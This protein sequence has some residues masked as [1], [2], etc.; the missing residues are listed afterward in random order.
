M[1]T[2]YQ[3]V[4]TGAYNQAFVGQYGQAN[5]A[6]VTQAGFGGAVSIKQFGDNMNASATQR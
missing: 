2:I 1:A 3:Q 4:Q 5:Q 6:S